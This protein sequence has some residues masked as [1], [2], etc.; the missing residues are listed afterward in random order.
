[1]SFNQ[2]DFSRGELRHPAPDLQYD[3]LDELLGVI[4]YMLKHDDVTAL[5]GE[6]TDKPNR[7]QRIDVPSVS[8]FVVRDTLTGY[9]IKGVVPKDSTDEDACRA[10]YM[11]M[12]YLSSELSGK[13]NI[14]ISAVRHVSMMTPGRAGL[15]IVHVIEPAK[16]SSIDDLF[17]T[18]IMSINGDVEDISFDPMHDTS[19]DEVRARLDMALT[20]RVR[21]AL[22]SDLHGGNIF[23]DGGQYTV[24]D[25]PKAAHASIALN[26][27]NQLA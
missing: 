1:M 20:E 23:T 25:Q 10:E 19:V 18:E 27:L 8:E 21:I 16:G 3:D 24:I 13:K 6:G 9:I 22:A 7:F 17:S 11:T 2:H 4:K 15:P 5:S 14:G 12:N 26:M